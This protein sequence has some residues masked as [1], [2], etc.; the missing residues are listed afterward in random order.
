MKV[1]KIDVAIKALPERRP[2]F[3]ASNLVNPLLI[4]LS[5]GAGWLA[6]PLK[7]MRTQSPSTISQE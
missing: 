3:E 6:E 4:S 1:V 2:A 7:G 5:I